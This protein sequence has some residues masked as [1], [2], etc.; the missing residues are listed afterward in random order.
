MAD[1]TSNL[2]KYGHRVALLWVVFIAFFV[3]SIFIPELA[4]L[5]GAVAVAIGGGQAVLHR[6]KIE[7]DKPLKANSVNFPLAW[8]GLGGVMVA[9]GA[10][11]PF[12]SAL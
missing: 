5:A 8:V 12:F 7:N 3:G 9:G 4:T 10:V 1:Q 6:S 2:M 11:V